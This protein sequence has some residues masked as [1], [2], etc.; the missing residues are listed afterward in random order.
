MPLS[1]EQIQELNKV[2]LYVSSCSDPAMSTGES[3]STMSGDA[4]RGGSSG[5]SS[6]WTMGMYSEGGLQ[7][8]SA[9]KGVGGDNAWGLKKTTEKF[10]DS[11]I[12]GLTNRLGG[13]VLQLDYN[14]FYNYS[15]S[16]PLRFSSKCF[17]VLRTSVEEDFFNPLLRLFFLTY[18]TRSGA[19]VQ[20]GLQGAIRSG[21]DQLES[22]RGRLQS[23]LSGDSSKV[24]N[25]AGVAIA[26]AG[27][28]IL[29]V[30]DGLAKDLG[31]FTRASTGSVYAMY[32]PPTFTTFG[33]HRASVYFNGHEV[34]YFSKT[35]SG[36]S[37]CYGNVYIPNVF[38]TGLSINIPKLYYH[39]GFP[40]VIEVSISYQTLRP[41][42]SNL[43]YDIVR[44]RI[45]QD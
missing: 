31:D 37:V 38:I 23:S 9:L 33:D 32:T 19:S 4:S 8:D 2:H 36:L 44:G 14:Q 24:L 26:D 1:I 20:E 3:D 27:S 21:L 22:W 34:R 16:E 17:L 39:G 11:L 35:G 10:S 7:I 15:G 5:S 30:F 40:Q 41:A 28:F 43:L 18:P 29:Q 12:G 6:V 42:T 13:Y 45:T 25:K